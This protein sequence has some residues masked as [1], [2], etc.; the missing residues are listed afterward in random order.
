[1]LQFQPRPTAGVATRGHPAMRRLAPIPRAHLYKID[2]YSVLWPVHATSAKALFE[3][4]TARD[5]MSA[6]GHSRP[7]GS[8]HASMHVRCTPKADKRAGVLGRPLCA[9]SGIC[10]APKGGVLNH[11]VARSV[12]GTS[13]P[14]ARF[15]AWCFPCF[16]KDSTPDLWQ[17]TA[18]L[19]DFTR[20]MGRSQAPAGLW[21]RPAS[22]A[23]M[24][25]RATSQQSDA[26]WNRRSAR[27]SRCRQTAHRRTPR[28]L[29]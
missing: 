19:W 22:P 11:L 10:T 7:M 27:S 18:A 20:P 26:K 8:N 14:S 4:S 29:D 13:R 28:I 9:R 6:S 1:M 12:G 23:R 21:V 2:H 17:E 25:C 3:R 16:R 24:K 5:W 15:N